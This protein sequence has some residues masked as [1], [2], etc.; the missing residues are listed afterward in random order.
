MTSKGVAL[1][2]LQAA[3]IPLNSEEPW[4]IHVHNEKLWDRVISQKQLGLGES[5]MEGWWDCDALDVMLTKLLSINVLTLLKPSPSLALHA[6]RSSLFNNQTKR[7]AA[8]N[9]KHHYNIGNELF[10]RMLDSEMAYS[11]GYWTKADSLAQAQLDKFDLI[12]RKLDL[13]PGMR[14]LDIGS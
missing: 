5:Y 12:C 10:S 4:S 7:R 13:Q 8:A 3:G 1:E 11:C 6:A 2:I 14:L 9:A